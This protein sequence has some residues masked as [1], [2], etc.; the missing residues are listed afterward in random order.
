VS[1]GAIHELTVETAKESITFRVD[2]VGVELRTEDLFDTFYVGITACEGI[3]R[4]YDF[5]IER[6]DNTQSGGLL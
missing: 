3:V 6:E 4:L 2:G 1:E 5:V